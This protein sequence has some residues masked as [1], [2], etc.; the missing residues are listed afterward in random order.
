MTNRPGPAPVY[1]YPDDPVPRLRRQT[2]VVAGVLIVLVAAWLAVRDTSSNASPAEQA[3]KLVADGQQAYL[4]GNYR[5]A[6]QDFNE[7]QRLDPNNAGAHFYLGLVMQVVDN[8]AA[9]AEAQY[10]Q[11][12]AADP[13][14]ARALFNLGVLR[15]KAGD[16]NEAID[17][18]R[19]AVAADDH[20]A[21]AHFNLGLLLREV[22]PNSQE[23]VA[24]L[25]RAVVLDGSLVSRIP[26]DATTTTSTTLTKH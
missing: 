19:R 16:R 6:R 12:I 13:R 7:G 11:A 2:L 9:G 4:D 24:E 26:E 3:T 14:F 17:L 21:S 5:T 23:A 10:R 25:Q 22:D 15:A 8:N 18:Y 1:K 20:L